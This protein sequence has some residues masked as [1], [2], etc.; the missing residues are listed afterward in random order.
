NQ[1]TVELLRLCSFLDADEIP[2]EIFQMGA[3]VLGES[4]GTVAASRVRIINTIQ[5]CGR[6]SLLQRNPE[7]RTVRLHRLFQA[8]IR[9]EMGRDDQRVWAERAVLA[10]NKTF[11]SLEFE[12]WRACGRLIQHVLTLARHINEYNIVTPEAARLLNRAGAYLKEHARY[13]EAL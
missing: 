4:L 8:Y 13:A 2:E 1:A 6:F 5:D 12:N 9:E 3:E 7:S 11:P 10:V